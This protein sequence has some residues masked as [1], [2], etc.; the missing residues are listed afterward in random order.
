MLNIYDTDTHTKREKEVI[1]L[2]FGTQAKVYKLQVV[3]SINQQV[4]LEFKEKNIE[5]HITA[6]TDLWHFL[7]TVFVCLFVFLPVLGLCVR[8]LGCG[9]TPLQTQ[10]A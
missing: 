3:V 8:I 5:I 2:R 7:V 1:Y 6:T 9:H 10:F 4:F